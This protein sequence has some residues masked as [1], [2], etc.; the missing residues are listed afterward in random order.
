MALYKFRIIIIIIIIIIIEDWP[1]HHQTLQVANDIIVEELADGSVI[2]NLPPSFTEGFVNIPDKSLGRD[3]GSS[4]VSGTDAVE[5]SNDDN[6]I[7]SE[8]N[9]TGNPET[10]QQPFEDES[11]VSPPRS[12]K[13]QAKRNSGQS[14]TN[15]KS[16]VVPGKIRPIQHVCCC[17]NIVNVAVLVWR[18]CRKS[19]TRFGIVQILTCKMLLSVL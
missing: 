16:E 9:G 15:S 2:I 6:D 1:N 11:D 19:L 7:D 4:F 12:R 17:K 3:L 13:R 18:N 5:L 14:Y 10:E 8:W